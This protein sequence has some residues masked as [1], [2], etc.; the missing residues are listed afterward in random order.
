[1]SR[2]SAFTLVELLVVIAIIGILIGML[3]PAVQVVREA[4]RRISCANNMRQIGLASHHH[5]EAFGQLPY[6]IGVPGQSVTRDQVRAQRLN[7]PASYPL[8]ILADFIEQSNVGDQID[9]LARDINAPQL[10]ATPYSSITNWRSGLGA[11]NPGIAS[12][13]T[14]NYPFAVCPSDPGGFEEN[15]AQGHHHPTS[16][17]ALLSSAVTFDGISVTNY[18]ACFG[19]YPVTTQP[20]NTSRVGFHGPIRSRESD[21]IVGITDGSSNVVLYGETLG[22]V[23]PEIDA[24][25]RPSLALGGGV[26]G[27]PDGLNFRAGTFRATIENVFGSEDRSFNTQFGSSHP[28]G[29]NLVRADGSTIFLPRNIDK[30]TFGFLCGSADG[31]VVPSY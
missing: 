15:R 16:D 14:G 21:S 6:Y 4:A 25:R 24:N 28:G 29:V 26:I 13:M 20:T 9:R 27:R 10:S 22:L 12:V 23:I 31:N 11:A 5:D 30:E 1:M 7:Q 17:G 18:V 3:L 2:R 8:V 19:G